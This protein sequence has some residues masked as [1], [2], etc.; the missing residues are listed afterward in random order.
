[1][2]PPLP[3]TRPSSLVPTHS[4]PADPLSLSLSSNILGGGTCSF[5]FESRK[6]WKYLPLIWKMTDAQ[7]MS[8]PKTNTIQNPL[9]DGLGNRYCVKFR[10]FQKVSFTQCAPSAYW[11]AL[12]GG[13]IV[14]VNPTNGATQ[15]DALLMLQT[16][17]LD[18]FLPLRGA[19][20]QGGFLDLL[21]YL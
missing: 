15:I 20:G 2:S 8:F 21:N 4:A 13:E 19:L 3:A 16:G 12:V 1:M 10:F 7:C 9:R 6:N 14:S 18:Q 11:Q 5:Y 17:G